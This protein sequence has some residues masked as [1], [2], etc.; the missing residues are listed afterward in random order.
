MIAL[1]RNRWK[2]DG[3]LISLARKCKFTFPANGMYLV[4]L[5]V[6]N[7]SGCTKVLDSAIEINDSPIPQ[8]ALF[9]TENQPCQ[10][11]LSPDGN[12]LM[13]ERS[14]S[15]SEVLT[16]RLFDVTG[17]LLNQYTL[18]A[19]SNQLNIDLNNEVPTLLVVELSSQ[20][21]ESVLKI[22]PRYL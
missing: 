16:I 20:S 5:E 10:C 18:A 22:D 21:F 12:K 11:A 19:S 1:L 6:T 17:K 9:E 4:S 13:I 14:Q 8:T 15:L 3:T 2:V 7:L